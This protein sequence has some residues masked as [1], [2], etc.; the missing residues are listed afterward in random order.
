MGNALSG[1]GTTA[2]HQW[3]YTHLVSVLHGQVGRVIEGLKQTLR[4]RQLTASQRKA[5]TQAIRYFANHRHWMRYDDY[6]K[7][8]YPIGSGVVES[9]CGHTV[10]DRMEGSGRRWSIEGAEATPLLRSIYTSNDWEAYWESHMHQERRRLYGNTFNALGIADTYHE[11]QPEKIHM[12]YHI[13]LT[14]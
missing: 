2:T 11:P 10:K 13:C 8:G 7:A 12:C 5:V 14:K 9:T 4:K 1:D 3:G 6:L